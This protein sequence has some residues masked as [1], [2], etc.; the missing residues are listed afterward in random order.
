[1]RKLVDWLASVLIAAVLLMNLA[2]V[3]V[4]GPLEDAQAAEKRDDTAT[5]IP[6]YLTLAEKGDLGAQK[7][8]GFFYEIGWGV[9]RDWTVAAKWY[10]KAADAGDA[11]A[12]G[13]LSHLGRN[14]PFMYPSVSDQTIY[15][16]VEAAARK[17]YAVAQMSLGVMNYT[18]DTFSN[19]RRNNLSE[20]LIWYRRAA[21]Q[22]NVDAEIALAMAYENGI[23]VPQDY[24]EAH[25]WLN[26]AASAVKYEDM[27]ED[28]RKRRDELAQ[29]MTASQ[30]AEAQK[31]AREWTPRP[32]Q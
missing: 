8:L 13:S 26:L 24:V 15:Q 19:L 30:I 16:L 5:A 23:G 28:L 3:S 27:R 9:N 29:K 31:L 25:K 12:A 10:A 2:D 6:I 32:E 20:A 1:M 18:F 17:G 11:D 4:A 7:R 21:A 14:L 22:G